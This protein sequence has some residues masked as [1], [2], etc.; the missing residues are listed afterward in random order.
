MENMTENLHVANDM[1]KVGCNDCRGCSSCCEGMGESIILDPYDIWQL[2]GKLP[3]TFAGLMQEK[4][5][6][7][8]EEGLI[9]PH[10]KMQGDKERCGFLDENGRC[11]IHAFRPGLCRLFPLG[12]N[13]EDHKLQYFLLQ[14][15][16]H[17]AGHTKM[18]IKK[19][20]EI[21]DIRKYET[22]LVTWHDLRKDLQQKIAEYAASSETEDR[23]KDI[24]MQFLHVF[25]EQQ[26]TPEDFYAQF[27]E[28]VSFIR[29]FSG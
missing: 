12:R 19:W 18:K 17:H 14:D 4:V 25:Y 23:I 10:L 22:F 11:G 13:Y 8:V 27:E 16:C 5:E 21:P 24:N 2:E 6:L 15:V 7:H 3:C 20:L 29:S 1:V 26:Y 9:L 28:R